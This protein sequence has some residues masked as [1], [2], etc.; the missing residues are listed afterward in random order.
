MAEALRALEEALAEAER[1]RA[2]LA[3][4]GGGPSQPL[5]GGRAGSLL[6]CSLR[7]GRRRRREGERAEAAAEAAAVAGA[8]EA[9]VAQARR[10]A[11]SARAASRAVEVQ[12]RERQA[13]R[14]AERERAAEI[15]SEEV[16]RWPGCR[17]PGG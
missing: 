17:E 9:A 6:A 15:E 4:T 1:R 2:A 8:Q 14:R 5:E 16:A 11:G 7:E 3:G 12:R 13:H 10:A